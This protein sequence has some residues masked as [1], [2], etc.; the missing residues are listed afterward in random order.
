VSGIIDLLVGTGIDGLGPLEPDAGNDLVAIQKQWGDR[1]ALVGNI[2]VDLLCRGTSDEVAA[3]T[4]AL[5]R[6]LSNHGTHARGGHVLSSGNTITSPVK[7]ENFLA[8]I[9]AGRSA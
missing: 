3:T 5:V 1:V 4:A 2:D 9:E 6:N 7:P 8:M